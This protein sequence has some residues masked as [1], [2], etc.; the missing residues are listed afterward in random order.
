MPPVSNQKATPPD[1]ILVI[2]DLPLIPLAFR[3]VFRSINPSATVEHTENIFSA[4]STKVFAN[5]HF[6]LVI[7]DSFQ[8]HFSGNLQQT[9]Q[10]L[11]N[12]FGQPLIMI[13]TSTYDPLIVEKMILTGIDAYVH[14]Y[15]SIE[16]IIKTYAQLSKGETYI[17]GIFH[18][19]YYEY[20]YGL[21]K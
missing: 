8:D 21:R 3:E 6:D 16:E 14:K 12:R 19:L 1:R 13:Y 7:A 10:E 18:A 17:S 20:G 9:V 15:E 11:K 5:T 4:L 2:D